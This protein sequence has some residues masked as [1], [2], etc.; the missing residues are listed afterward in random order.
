MFLVCASSCR[1]ELDVF[2]VTVD[3]PET[4]VFV[5]S[6]LSGRVLD[7]EG[8]GLSGVPVSV[9]DNSKT[10]NGQ[11]NFSFDNIIVEK[12]K[13]LITAEQSTYFLG[14]A[15]SDF[16]ADAGSF[17]EITM[18]EKGEASL[19]KT[20]EA[21]NFTVGED[22]EIVVPAG[23]LVDENGD[24]AEGEA[25]LFSRYIDPTSDEFGNQMPG[26]LS[27]VDEDGNEEV[28]ETFGMM[29]TEFSD[30]EEELLIAEGETMKVNFKIPDELLD[31][32]PDELTI[33]L[34][35]LEEEQWFPI[36]N[37][38][39]VGIYYECNISKPGYICIARPLRAICLSGTVFNAD[40]TFS[41]YLKVQV[42]DLSTHYTYFGYTDLD[43]YFCGSV[44]TETEMYF[45]IIDLCGNEIF[46]ETVGPF[47]NHHY[48]GDVYL[49]VT[50][51]EYI[52]N[53]SGQIIDCNS[54]LLDSGY[55]SV[56]YPSNTRIFEVVDGL[57]NADI[58]LKCVEFPVLS[59]QA[60]SS[61]EQLVS[62]SLVFTEFGDVDLGQEVI[63][64]DL[65]E[66]FNVS[67]DGQEFWTSPVDFIEKDNTGTN[68][69]VV[70]GMAF[71]H[72]FLLDIEEYS[73]VGTYTSAI[74]LSGFL[75]PIFTNELFVN[76]VAPN[77]TL[78]VLVDDGEFV[79]GSLTGTAVDVGGQQV[80]VE[81]S[82]K[83]KRT[84]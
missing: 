29:V 49:D 5:E 69:W 8:N 14:I 62:D 28:L 78:D 24:L 46:G 71:E 65:L 79:E 48:L 51:N 6:S 23:M 2:E 82:F 10:T 22:L 43:G 25:E 39:K 17:V 3:R 55:I 60:Y 45:S 18:V 59:I 31:D 20:D 70:H 44:P 16:R 72:E 81:G 42:E 12:S 32:A 47:S 30:E 40:S 41:S 76:S 9:G 77:L 67:I 50:V 80:D 36:D 53:I 56:S 61:A 74:E 83:L 38:T 13:A 73:G 26:S 75:D 66:Y 11:G 34:F 54:A 57:V 27:T 7:E 4:K 33:Y 84:N 37:C 68:W 1:E 21:N 19:I 35:D 52:L 63:C 58:G 15:T 64:E